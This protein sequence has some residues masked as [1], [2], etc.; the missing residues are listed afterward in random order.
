M[1]IQGAANTE[2][3]LA[4]YFLTSNGS[5]GLANPNTE[6]PSNWSSAND[7]NLGDPISTAGHYRWNGLF[8]RDFAAGM[9][10]V[11]QP[12]SPTTTV[13]L[14]GTYRRLDGTLVTSVTL[15]AATG[16]VLVAQ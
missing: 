1:Q 2:Y 11:N 15:A 5:D 10:V 6:S 8:R 7:V 13:N 9:T 16:A 3:A 14:G 4:C 12:G